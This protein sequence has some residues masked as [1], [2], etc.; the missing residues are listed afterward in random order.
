M[1]TI[2]SIED[3]LKDCGESIFLEA[4]D[5]VGKEDSDIDNDGDVD[6]SDKYLHKRRKAISKSIATRKE[7]LDP[8]GKED[9]D[10][11]ND[12][13]VDKSDSYLRHR[14]KVRTSAIKPRVVKEGYSDWKEDLSE[15]MNIVNKEKNEK[16]I[17]EREVKNKIKINPSLGESIENLGG[18]LLEM[19]EIDNFENFEGIFDYLSESEIF[20]LSDSLIEEVVIEFFEECIEEDYDPLEIES[21]LLESIHISESI[22][23]EANVTLGHDTKVKS[24]RLQKVKSAVKKVA[25]GAGY[26]AGTGVRGAKAA[27]R[28][29]KSGVKSVARGA[30][31]A[32]GAAVRG[33][34]AVGREAQSGYE[35]GRHGESGATSQSQK[36]KPGLLRRIGSLLKRGLKKA[37]GSDETPS[38]VHSK[39]GTRTAKT[40][41]GIGGGRRVEVAGSPSKSDTSVK[42]VSVKDVTPKSAQSKPG[43]RTAKTYSGVGGGKKV[44][45]AGRPTPSTSDQPSSKGKMLPGSAP[46]PPRTRTKKASVTQTEPT[47]KTPKASTKKTST[48]TTTPKPPRTKKAPTEPATA[49]TPTPKTSKK[50]KEPN[51]K[52][53]G[54]PSLDDLL[55]ME[56]TILDEKTLSKAETQEKERLVKRMKSN[57]SDFEKR[58][59]GRGKEVMYATA[60]KMAKKIAEQVS[61]QSAV[62]QVLQAK[63]KAGTAQKELAMKQRMASQKGVDLASLSS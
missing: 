20:L 24:D 58:Y 29:I 23:S 50:K 7:A 2:S 35:R 28:A 47:P 46:K 15:I 55:K 17:K 31:Y 34:K 6:K 32:A 22:L 12:G 37:I 51:P 42:K 49:A 39:A 14:R 45:V 10:I 33:A 57:L 1:P 18:T 48:T 40:Y 27:G 63:Q 43:T 19:V 16:I 54:A 3:F 9:S 26:A 52:K 25:Y 5:P 36:S 8:V 13:D 59:P 41:S 53:E 60:T 21:V 38:S 62:S 44:E 56:S 11:D 30:G 4:L 61:T